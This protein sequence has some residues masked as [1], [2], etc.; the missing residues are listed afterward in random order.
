[1]DVGVMREMLETFWK[2]TVPATGCLSLFPPQHSIVD[3]ASREIA[4]AL[5]G[6]FLIGLFQYFLRENR[7]SSISSE[8]ASSAELDQEQPMA[9]YFG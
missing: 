4:I 6:V 7:T 8:K 9:N 2:F 1:M 3:T 5:V